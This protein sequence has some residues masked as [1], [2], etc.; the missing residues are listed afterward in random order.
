MP[1][2]RDPVERFWEKVDQSGD[3][4][5]WT[6]TITQKGYGQFWAG[7]K[8][9]Y[10]HRY[11][12]ELREQIPVGEQLDHR[13]TCPKH[14]VNPE[15]L[16]PA[17]NK[18]NCENRA[19]A[20]SNSKTGVRGV[21]W[22]KASGKYRVTVRHNYRKYYGGEFVTIEEAQAAAIILRSR[23]FTHNDIDRSVV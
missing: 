23:L 4:W 14:C 21:F 3:C 17:T 18:Q 8:M 10:A 7:D 1:I 9:V 13:H 20:Y 12:Y 16:R 19:G 5:L 6:G 15:H 11:A 2:W 22:E